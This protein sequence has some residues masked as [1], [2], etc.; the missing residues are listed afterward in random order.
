MKLDK[1]R[2]IP[3]KLSNEEWVSLLELVKNTSEVELSE[4]GTEF[5]TEL[6]LKLRHYFV[7][8]SEVL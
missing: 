2:T 5:W 6:Y 8:G 7:Y 1:R 3:L 4:E